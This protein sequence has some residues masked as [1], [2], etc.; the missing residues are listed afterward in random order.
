MA[1]ETGRQI[2]D[3]VEKNLRPSDI[4][5][6]QSLENAIRVLMA[7][8]GSTNAVVHLAAIAGRLGIK[9]PLS[10]FDE[11]SKNT[12]VLANVKPSGEYLM[13]DLFY[14]GGVSALMRELGSLL[15]L[16]KMTV[17]GRTLGEEIASAETFDSKVIKSVKQP[18]N[19]DGGLVILSGNLA[20]NGA[21]LKQTAASQHLFRHKGRAVVFENYSDMENRV[22]DP[23]LDVTED[24]VLVLRNI[25]PKGGPGFPE[26]GFMPIPQK[27]LKK[28]VRDMVRINDGRM[29]GTAYGMIALHISPEAA[30]GGPLAAVENGDP[31]FID[32]NA[33]KLEL[34]IPQ[35]DLEKRLAKFKPAPP[36]YQ[37]GYRRLFLEHI[38]QAE[39]GCDFDFLQA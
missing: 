32:V 26:W 1:E 29:S 8:G 21:I 3:L 31:I 23:S 7:V 12:P 35:N 39:D 19:Q 14:A 16:D 30:V 2:V 6:M 28:G 4:I 34:H 13:E 25:G 22:D 17:S 33:R 36:M 24:D 5:D 11:I 38:L 18:L 37:R 27:L 10:I 15:H 20:P 9:L